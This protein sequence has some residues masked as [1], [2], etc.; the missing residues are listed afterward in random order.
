MKKLL[1]IALLLSTIATN[2]QWTQ[3]GQDI[4]GES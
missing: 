1:I 2:A 4:Y 3:I